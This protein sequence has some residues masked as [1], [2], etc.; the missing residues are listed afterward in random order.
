M[1]ITLTNPIT[2]NEGG[3]SLE[4]SMSAAVMASD[5]D[6]SSAPTVVFTFQTVVFTFQN[7]TVNGA[8]LVPGSITGNT[9][10]QMSVNLITGAW[11]T[12]NGLSGTLSAQDLVTLLNG[13]IPVRNA[14]EV[15]AIAYN[16]IA[17][18]Q[19]PWTAQS[20]SAAKV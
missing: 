17:G 4:N 7:G 9:E 6:F 13:L 20:F 3:K 10:I 11:A 16:V 12:S 5:V 2:V 8:T 14:G 1:S 18:Q 19:V 15:L